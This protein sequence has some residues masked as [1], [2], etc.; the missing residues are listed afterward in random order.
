MPPVLDGYGAPNYG[1]NKE[2]NKANEASNECPKKDTYE[3]PNEAAAGKPADQGSQDPG[4]TWAED[5]PNVNK[6]IP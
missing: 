6:L 5:Q 3:A 2:T 1:S 4:Q